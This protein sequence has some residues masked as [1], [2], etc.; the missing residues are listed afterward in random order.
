MAARILAM[1]LLHDIMPAGR[2]LA[3]PSI[4]RAMQEGSRSGLQDQPPPP[5]QSHSAPGTPSKE[6]PP[7]ERQVHSDT[8]LFGS[9]TLPQPLLPCQK[10]LGHH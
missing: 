1:S 4:G 5:Q 9:H 2:G 3:A 8:R 6:G 7:P 10:C